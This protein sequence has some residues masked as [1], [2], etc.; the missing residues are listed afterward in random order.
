MLPVEVLDRAQSEILSYRDL[1]MSVMELNHRSPEFREILDGAEEALRKLMNIPAN[2]KILFLQG[3]AS[4]QFAAVPM[5]LLSSHRCADYIVSGQFSKKAKKYGDILIAASSGGAS[6]PYSTVPVTKRSDFRPDADYVH[7][8]Y[9]N[10]IYGTKFHYI[11]D[12]GNIPLVADMTSCICS[13]PIDVTKFGLIYASAQVNIGV[14]GLTIVIVRNDLIGDAR[15]DTPAMLD[16][17]LL[18]ES[19][20][21]Y[22]TP[23]VYS[24]YMAKLVL[25]WILSVGGLEEMKRRNEKKASML[26]DYLDGQ[27]Q[28]Y[29]TAPV[30][31][32]CR[33]MMNVVFL[34]GDGE[35]DKKFAKEAAEAGMINL[36]GHPSVGGMCASMYNSMPYE[37]VERLISFMKE[38]SRNNPK[39]QR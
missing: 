7:I 21:V 13:E 39:L 23:P 17:K 24:I 9:N 32:K 19:G 37:G 36:A 31:K 8:C 11:P 6:P 4:S 22:N 18:S 30:D 33:S 5:N 14:A 34:T 10:T 2:Y 28:S 27:G 25:E 35:L 26:Y 20:S 29:Y 16:Y 1:G 12:T 38:F 15:S 3:G